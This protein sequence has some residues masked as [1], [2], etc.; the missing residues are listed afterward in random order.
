M[1]KNILNAAA[2]AAFVMACA[3]LIGSIIATAV[4]IID[5]DLTVGYFAV[6]LW[7]ALLGWAGMFA[8]AVDRWADTDID[9]TARIQLD[10]VRVLAE[11]HYG[12]DLDSIPVRAPAFAEGMRYTAGA[13]LDV[14]DFD[15]ATRL[16]N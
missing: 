1:P 11:T 10:A 8:V 15:P 3:L 14:L 16:E 7:I 4:S 9:D 12:S 5:Q 2:A 6:I 13:V